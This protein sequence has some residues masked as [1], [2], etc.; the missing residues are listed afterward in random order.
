LTSGLPKTLFTVQA[1]RAIAAA[2]VVSYHVLFM[3]VHSGGYAFNVS[4]IG[5][6][7]VDLFFLISG[8]IYT[9]YDVFARPGAPALFMRRRIIRVVPM[10]WVC[11]TI[12]VVLLVFAPR[13]FSF[14]KFEMDARNFVVS[15][16]IVR[17]FGGRYRHGDPNG[18][19]AVLRVLFLCSVC[20][21][22]L[23]AA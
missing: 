4:T 7:G 11:T 12:V 6:A 10:Y 3:L 16:S 21:A 15:L 14:V 18:M 19:D 9:N 1:L 22:A 13:L 2:A 5:G 17:K 20:A 8:M 23:L